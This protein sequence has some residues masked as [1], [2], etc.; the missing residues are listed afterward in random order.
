MNSNKV[1]I[2]NRIKEGQ[3]EEVLKPENYLD[4]G[5]DY[6]VKAEY[7]KA[8]RAY[9]IG[10][11][12]DKLNDKIYCKMGLTYHNLGK[13]NIAIK[14]YKKA[15]KINKENSEAQYYLGFIYLQE[16]QDEKAIK[17]LKD[18]LN[19]NPEISRAYY[20]L[21][22]ALTRNNRKEE[23]VN[24]IKK[25]I[26]L[27]CPLITPDDI[28]TFGE[29]MRKRAIEKHESN[30]K[31]KIILDLLLKSINKRGI[32]CFGDSHRSV[33][34]NIQKINC[35]NTGSGTAYNLNNDKSTSGS[36]KRI[37][38]VLENI[39]KDEYAILLVYGEIDCME[40]IMKNSYREDKN[41]DEITT[42]LAVKYT[43]YIRNLKNEGYTVLVYGPALSGFSFNSHGTQEE[44]NRI[45]RNFNEQIE[46]N[47]ST[48]KRVYFGSINKIVTNDMYEP[49][50]KL[51][52]DGR[53][54]DN[55][56]QGSKIVQGMIIGEFI[57]DIYSKR[58]K[59]KNYAK[60]ERNYAEGKPYA[61]VFDKSD[62][63][64]YINEEL[65]FV[66]SKSIKL[67]EKEKMTIVIDMLN[68]YKIK[69]IIIAIERIDEGYID[70]KKIVMAEKVMLF[71]EKKITCHSAEMDESRH[72][73]CCII[74]GNI[75]ARGV[76][77]EI[78]NHMPRETTFMLRNI[79]II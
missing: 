8:I 69:N 34:N 48:E 24:I 51:S 32:V 3:E 30:D 45:M 44:R 43:E 13:H 47:L 58:K 29:V 37:K 38:K 26:E 46:K 17:Y 22:E 72:N 11:R 57:K 54:L 64:I 40:H 65:C 4:M 62:T 27:N 9:E 6:H 73:S 60:R 1:S 71:N 7:E 68:H 75:I 33:F 21:C 63:G 19:L 16:N 67:K 5:F 52:K 53:H 36:G 25:R 15:T 18:A 56:P 61:I 20:Y 31:I 74:K 41:I 78:K 50:M 77:I 76:L 55:F 12:I 23:A 42:K 14:Y 2:Y 59:I 10:T 49:E 35:Y 79:E 70:A 66:K 39:N 28:F